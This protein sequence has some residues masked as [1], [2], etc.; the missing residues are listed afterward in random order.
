M[1]IILRN[2]LLRQPTG[3]SIKESAETAC[4]D[5]LQRQKNP[6]YT[7]RFQINPKGSNVSKWIQNNPKESKTIQ[8]I[9]KIQKYSKRFKNIPKYSRWF[10]NIPERGFTENYTA[11]VLGWTSCSNNLQRFH[12]NLKESIRIQKGI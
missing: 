10:Q 4:R 11:K 9:Q 8:R 12:K 1:S 2:N 5:S 7:N 6:K 3:I